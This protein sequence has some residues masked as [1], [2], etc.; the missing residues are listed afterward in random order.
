MTKAEREMMDRIHVYGMILSLDE[1]HAKL[2]RAKVE[3]YLA[4]QEAEAK[5]L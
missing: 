2:F 3:E 4:E 5:K 1:K